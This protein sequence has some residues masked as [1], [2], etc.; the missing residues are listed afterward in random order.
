MLAILLP[1]AGIRILDR[2][3]DNV[4][5]SERFEK[6]RKIADLVRLNT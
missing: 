1:R 2:Q 4:V 5:P 3:F 6:D